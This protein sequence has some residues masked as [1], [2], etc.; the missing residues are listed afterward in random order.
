VYGLA[1]ENNTNGVTG[2]NTS[3]GPGV[4]GSSA[5]GPG[6]YGYS[7][8]SGY[9]VYG[10]SVGSYAAYF[11]GQVY[12]VGY[13]WKPGGGFKIDHPLDPENKYLYHSFVE[14]PDMKNVYDGVVVLD[15]NGEAWVE[16]PAWFEALNGGKEHRSD[17][18]YQLTA[19]GAPGPNL[20][21]AEEVTNNRFQIAGGTPGMK[22]S[23]QV[24]G[25]RHDPY[26]EANR[27]LVEEPKPPEERG[28][29]L[30]PE[31]YGLPETMGLAYKKAQSQGGGE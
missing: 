2:K 27:I 11:N 30:H 16:L 14:S 19:I 25:I 23:W 1:Y 15:D 31:A 4:Y 10:Y 29:Y 20:Y 17:F 22:V 26:A 13:L 5:S 8:G 24:T 3:A 7:E 28:T 6:V 9:G 18:R 21:I 12:V